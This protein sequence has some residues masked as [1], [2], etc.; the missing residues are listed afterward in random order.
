MSTTEQK[1]RNWT[2]TLVGWAVL[3]VILVLFIAA[4]FVT[5]E[6]RFLGTTTETRLAYALLLASLLGFVTGW[7]AAI[8]RNR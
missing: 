7:L 2:L 1:R 5:V 6:V 3:M 8:L 4:N